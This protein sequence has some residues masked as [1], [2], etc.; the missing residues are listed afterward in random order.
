MNEDATA[1]ISRFPDRNRAIR[2]LIARN[3]GFRD[4]CADL[5]VA[6]AE[7]QKWRTSADPRRERR[8]DEYL[9]LVEELAVEIA[10]TLD[11]AAVVPFPKR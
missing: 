11:A 7:L 9:V 3:D 5:A 2:D 4:M 10:N 6:E 1:A 8:I